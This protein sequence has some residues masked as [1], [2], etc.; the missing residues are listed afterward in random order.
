MQFG[1]ILPSYLP[2]AS[3]GGLRRAAELAEELGYDSVWTTDHVMMP[4]DGLSHY[5]SVF[6][7]LTTMAWLAAFTSKIKIGVS[8]LVL[9]QRHPVIVA[10]EVATLDRLSGGRAIVGLGA[11]WSEQEFGYL[12]ANFKD[13]GRMLDEAILLLRQLWSEPEKAFR[14]SF[15]R[16]ENQ[17]FAPPPAQEGGPPIWIG[18][19]SNAALRRA[20]SYGDGWHSAGMAPEDFKVKADALAALRPGRRLILSSRVNANP[21]STRR[22]G[23]YAFPEDVPRQREAIARYAEAGCSYLAMNFWHGDTEAFED[24]ARHF[25]GEIMAKA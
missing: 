18:G 19:S 6:E 22:P 10:K 8:V 15:F 1:L 12:D 13:R 21:P 20:A 2:E 7:V 16:F 11:G 5:F 4:R 14:G 25:A 17:T 3:V 24:A 23:S 9:P